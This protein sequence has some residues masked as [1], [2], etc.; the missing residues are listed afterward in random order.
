MQ[1]IDHKQERKKS[2][3]VSYARAIFQGEDDTRRAEQRCLGSRLPYVIRVSFNVRVGDQ[4][5]SLPCRRVPE[6]GEG[7]RSEQPVAGYIS[8]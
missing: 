8:R 5:T 6:G 2:L 3:R 1:E 7:A 4:L